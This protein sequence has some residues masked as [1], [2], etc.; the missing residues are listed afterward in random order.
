LVGATPG[1]IHGISCVCVNE[2]IISSTSWLSPTVR[3]T[4]TSEV[5]GGM[6]GMKS[7]E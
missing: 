4:G 3:D 2:K 6:L 5:S 7:F 1:S